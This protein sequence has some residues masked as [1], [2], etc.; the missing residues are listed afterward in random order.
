MK[1][2]I[3]RIKEKNKGGDLKMW[4]VAEYL[5]GPFILSISIGNTQSVDYGLD[6]DGSYKQKTGWAE[7]HM[8]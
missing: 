8:I 3:R 7:F 4:Q 6:Y 5:K 1:A 2:H